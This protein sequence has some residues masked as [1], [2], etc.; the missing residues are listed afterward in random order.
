MQ[1]IYYAFMYLM[2]Q[3]HHKDGIHSE[4]WSLCLSHKLL[5]SVSG[6]DAELRDTE[7]L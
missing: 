3:K 7:M 4:N 6:A 5:L 1:C 2:V